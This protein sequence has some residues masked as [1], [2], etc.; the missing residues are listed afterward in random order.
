[1]GCELTVKMENGT[2]ASVSGYTC[3]RGKIYAEKEVT[4]PVRVVTTT[5]R[6]LGGVLP[7]VPVKTRTDIPKELV[8]A[9]V[10]ELRDL[11]VEAP[12]QI[13]QTILKNAAGTGV[14]VAATRTVERKEG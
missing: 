14:E 1:M 10:R 6:V 9:C 2:V 8:F 12:V 5:V 11:T 13:G 4:H 3:R 7:V